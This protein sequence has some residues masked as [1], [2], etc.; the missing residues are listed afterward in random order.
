[1]LLEALRVFKRS[2]LFIVEVQAADLVLITA[3]I[4]DRDGAR[5]VLDQ[6]V[7]RDPLAD[8]ALLV[9]LQHS[10]VELRQLVEPLQNGF[11]IAD[12]ELVAP[13]QAL[14]IRRV[15]MVVRRM[16]L[17][18]ASQH[19]L[20]GE[21]ELVEFLAGGGQWMVLEGLAQHVLIPAR[22]RLL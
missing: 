10:L 6:A 14:V 18:S 19:L 1:M 7:L 8:I 11:V 20:R 4:R 17:R 22:R 15:G 16:V 9:F 3:R 21:R 5:R 2:I 12:Q 13:G